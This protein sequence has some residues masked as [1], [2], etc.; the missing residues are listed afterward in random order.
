LVSSIKL[1]NA[2]QYS[3]S[4]N[5]VI[6]LTQNGYSAGT[7]S[8]FDVDADGIVFARYSNGQSHIL[9]QVAMANFKNPQGLRRLGDNNWAQSYGSGEP[10]YGGRVMAGWAPSNRAHSKTRTSI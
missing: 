6:D 9:G 2:T 7:L 10:V 3:S 1:D 4:K 5:S 8:G